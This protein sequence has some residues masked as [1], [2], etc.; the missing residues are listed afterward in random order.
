MKNTGTLMNRVGCP[1]VCVSNTPSIDHLDY[2]KIYSKTL[3]DLVKICV[4]IE[5]LQRPSILDLQKQV[6]TGY[7]TSMH[8]AQNKGA[9]SA[10]L[11]IDLDAPMADIDWPEP[12]SP[13]LSP[14]VERR[15][16]AETSG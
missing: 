11:A 13:L 12:P 8:L 7:A 16:A 6:T 5:P 10:P 9:L 14:D 4:E 2:K 1:P 15:P 3:R